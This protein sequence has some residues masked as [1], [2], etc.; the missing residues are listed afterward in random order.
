MHL[1]KFTDY[2]LRVLIYLATEPD[3]MSTI[4]EISDRYDI[5]KEHLRKIV[6]HL[7]QRGWID[8]RR[9]RG[10]GLLLAK[11]PQDIPI[12]AVIRATEE[13]LVIVECFD[14]ARDTCQISGVCRLSGMLQEALAAFVAVLDRY[15]L[16]DVVAGQVALLARLGLSPTDEPLAFPR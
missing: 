14:P 3:R 11:K 8:S 16:Q 13:D 1:S 9:G 10:G 12:G 4:T 6:H 7:A 5:S 15:T 2:S